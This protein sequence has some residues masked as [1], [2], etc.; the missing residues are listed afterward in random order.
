MKGMAELAQRYGVAYQTHLSESKVQEITALK[1]YGCSLTQHLE[2]LGVLGPA[3]SAA[4]GVWLADDDMM[5]LADHGVPVS[6]NPGSNLRL[7]AGIANMRRLL[8]RGVV[9]GIGTD[10]A[11]CSDNQNM[12]EAMRLASYLSR[13]QD[14]DRDRWVSAREAAL[15]STEGSARVLGFEHIGRLE[16]GYRADIVFIDLG[17]AHWLPVRNAVHQLVQAEDATAVRHVMIDGRW[18]VRDRRLLTLDLE[19]LRGKVERAIQRIEHAGAAAHDLFRK[20]EPVVAS[21]CP[22]LA[23]TPHH[24]HRY[25]GACC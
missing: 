19:A 22:G 6:L 25:A 18:V 16:P 23:R 14:V 24:V 13:V 8:D 15:A 17:T 2:R 1:R 12:Y 21:F 5:R 10:S 4:H 3:M 9:V 11:S 20:F 7:G